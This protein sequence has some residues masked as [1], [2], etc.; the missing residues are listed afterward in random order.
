MAVSVRKQ[1]LLLLANESSTG[2]PGVAVR[3]FRNPQGGDLL[4]ALV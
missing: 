1:P 4:L 3:Q 2:L